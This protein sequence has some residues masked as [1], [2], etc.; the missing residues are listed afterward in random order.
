VG[1]KRFRECVDKHIEIYLSATTRQEKSS[2]VSNIF[3][4]ARGDATQP[5][6]G[7]VKKVCCVV[8][9]SYMYVYW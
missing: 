9:N 6:G 8:Y 5:H 3:D 1:N 7:F 4:A 2:I